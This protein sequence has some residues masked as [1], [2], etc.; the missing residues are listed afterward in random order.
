M[1]RFFFF[2]QRIL[3]LLRLNCSKFKRKVRLG[4]LL[5]LLDCSRTLIIGSLYSW[6]FLFRI[7][8]VFVK[9]R[10]VFFILLD[11]RCNYLLSN[12]KWNPPFRRRDY[13]LNS[14][15][16]LTQKTQ[17]PNHKIITILKIQV[18]AGSFRIPYR[19]TFIILAIIST[20]IRK[21]AVYIW[22]D[23]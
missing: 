7:W 2:T 15:S 1:S 8:L 12:F 18:K 4:R 6:T 21:M 23:L 5:E 9:Y 3:L 17:L 13:L 20:S 22:K 11:S 10:A 19:K 14:K 16:G